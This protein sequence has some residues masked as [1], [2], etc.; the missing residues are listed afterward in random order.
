MR[1]K[2]K[3]PSWLN[4]VINLSLIAILIVSILLLMGCT[5]ETCVDT[6]EVIRYKTEETKYYT[7]TTPVY[8]QVCS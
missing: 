4:A 3:L 2:R 8:R 1:S 6:D 5:S 7:I